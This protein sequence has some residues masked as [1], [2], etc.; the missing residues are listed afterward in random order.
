MSL[1][2]VLVKEAL[3]NKDELAPLRVVDEKELLQHDIFRVFNS[4]GLPTQSRTPHSATAFGISEQLAGW[5]PAA[6][7]AS[8]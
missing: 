6:N 8:P 2:D 5:L 3:K 1:F 7:A 4:A